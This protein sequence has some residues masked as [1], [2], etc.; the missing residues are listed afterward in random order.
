M[1]DVEGLCTNGTGDDGSRLVRRE[2]DAPM[3]V[4]TRT[5]LPSMVSPTPTTEPS[6]VSSH[7][8]S[9]PTHG[10]TREPTFHPT[11]A[12]TEV[13]SR[14]PTFNPNSLSP[15]PRPTSN[16]NTQIPTTTFYRNGISKPNRTS[17]TDGVDPDSSVRS[18]STSIGYLLVNIHW[19][20]SL[21]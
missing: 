4:P 19:W 2:V 6:V 3:G 20:V 11:A 8:T 21:R 14:N 13:S 10:P 17:T 16:I 12:P 15:I 7:P 1:T 5:S 18:F 9:V